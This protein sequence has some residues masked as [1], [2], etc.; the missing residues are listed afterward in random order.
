MS[1][2]DKLSI[3]IS[4]PSDL[5]TNC[6]PNGDG[7]VAFEIINHLARRGYTLHVVVDQID[8]QCPLPEN[9]RIYPTQIKSSVALIRRLLYIIK[10]RQ[11]FHQICQKSSLD[12]I[13]QLNP[14]TIGLSFSLLGI[15]LP[16][17]LG[18]IVAE[19]PY[20]AFPKN[21][22]Q[23]FQNLVYR[24]SK[25]LK[26]S[27]LFLQ[28]IQA[29]ALLIATPAALNK[30]Y[31]PESVKH[32]L[33]DFRHGVNTEFFSPHPSQNCNKELSNQATTNIILFVGRISHEKGVSTLLEAFELVISTLPT[34]QL[35]IAGAWDDDIENTKTKINAMSCRS[36]IQTLGVISR[37]MMP[38]VIRKCTVYCMP[39]YGEAFGM[40]ALEAMACGK[41]IVGTN[42]GGLAY[43]ISEK[44][45]RKVPPK[46]AY[47]LAS[48]LIEVLTSP[49]LQS[50]M[51]QFNRALVVEKYNWEKVIDQ[52][53]LI[54]ETCISNI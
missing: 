6:Q 50:E 14:G 1:N 48:A 34:C 49:Q 7:L 38:D 13:H 47:A 25:N 35:V 22:S 33:Y 2:S 43:L 15:K 4:H 37:E 44:G 51:G 40:G 10:V 18:P 53:E 5:L 8:I 42:A 12:I 24:V 21:Q 36:Q 9:V 31:H 23:I 41:P 19:W 3:F 32:K 20:E 39:S 17:V 28:Q 54:Y 45:G 30:V 52:L 27:L 11:K 16:F 26:K 46:D 29:N